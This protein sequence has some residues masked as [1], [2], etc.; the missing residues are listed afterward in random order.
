MKTIYLKIALTVIVLL[1]GYLFIKL[2]YDNNLTQ[3]A[4]YIELFIVDQNEIEVYHDTIAYQENQTFFDVLN[5]NFELTCANRNYE[6]D[7]TCSYEFKTL[8]SYH[9]ILG[10]KNEDFSILT[11]WSNTFIKIYVFD[12]TT[13]IEST[14]GVD[15]VNLNQI[16]SIKLVVE[17]VGV[18]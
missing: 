12:G 13:Y 8:L 4:G 16:D 9:V 5:E 6:P 7:E 17:E 18:S 2:V 3:T 15:G 14:V 10:I 11:D 1:L